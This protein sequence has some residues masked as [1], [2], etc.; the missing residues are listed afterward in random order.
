MG[1][2]TGWLLLLCLVTAGK[3]NFSPTITKFVFEVCEDVPIDSHAFTIEATDPD[4]DTLTYALSGASAAFFN[5][6]PNT[7]VVTVK[8]AL[9]RESGV[10]MSVGVTVGDGF[11]LTPGT[12]T[13]ILNDANDNSPVFQNP[14]FDV[15]VQENTAV[16]T[17]LFK[18]TATDADEGDAGAVRYSITEAV[19]AQGAEMFEID[20]INGELK[21]KGKLN[22]V[23][24]SFYRL[25][26]TAK[27][28]GGSCGSGAHVVQSS[29]VFSFIT[30]VDVPDLDPVFISAPYIG[31]VEENSPVD[32]SVLTVTAIDQDR[33]INDKILYS[34]QDSTADGLFKISQDDGIISV[35]SG[36]DREVTG[37][38]VTLTV[39]A[40]ESK[41]NVNGQPATATATVQINIIDVNDNPPQ[42][43]KCDMPSSCV[44]AT[45]FTGEVFEHSL[46]AISINMTVK[47]P[48]RFVKTKLSLEGPD[49]DVFSV[50]PS[51]AGAESVVQLLVSQPENLD[52]E[53]KQQMILQM[54]AVDEDK[55]T[56]QATATV[57]IIIKD[58]NDNSP[59]F[60]Q[61]T[62]K[63]NVSEHSP[64]GTEVAL[65][66]AEDPDTMDAGKLTYSLLP[67][68]ILEYF[69]V[70]S[71]TGKVYVKNEDLLDRELRSLFSAT[72]QARDTDGNPGTTV[73]EITLTDINDQAPIINRAIYR[74]FV[75]EGSQ[76]AFPIEATDGDEAG[77][78]NSEIV[79]SI[80]ESA[81][82]HNFSIDA[83]TGMLKN[84]GELD[85]EVLDPK[86]NG[87]I[88][89]TVF[90]TDK[91]TPPLNSSVEV[92]ITVGDINDNTPKFK[93]ESYNF[94]I[95]EGEKGASVGFV[96][97]K[98]LDQTTE[99]NR[100]SFSIIDGSFGSF[101]VRSTADEEG[102]RGNIMV[103]PD[104]EL[105]YESARKKFMLRLEA[106]DLEQEK[107]SVMVEVHVL[108][109]NDERPEF[110]P[111]SGISVKENTTIIEP[112]GK[113]IALDKD[114]NHSLVYELESVKCSCNGTEK[115]C[116][117][118]T[119]DPNGDVRVNQ[120]ETVDYEECDKAVMEVQVVDLYTEKGESNSIE[121]GK[122][123]INIEDINDNA[124]QFIYSDS[125]LVVVSESASK[126][127]SVAGVK[128][129]DRDSG[130][131]RQINFKV[132][133]VQFENMAT[134]TTTD[135]RIPFEAVTTQQG[136]DYVG[137]IQ[138]TEALD[139]T[140]KGKYLVT[141][142]ATDSGGLSSST[143]L[144]I[145][146][147][148]ETFRTD[149]QFRT[150]ELEVQNSLP[151]ITRA[152]TTA[153]SAAVE[154]VDIKPVSRASKNAVQT[155]MRAYFIYRNGTALTRP[156][157]EKKL[158]NPI[159][160]VVL[161][162]LGLINIGSPPVVETESD[163]VKYVLL[164]MVAG[165]V[166]VLAVLTTSLLC[167]RRNFRRKLKAANA[168]KST[169][170]L[171][172]DN[173]KGGAVVPGTNKY[174]M[175]GANPVLNLNIDT[176]I[177]LDLDSNEETSDSDKVSLNSLD[178]EYGKDDDKKGILWDNE[179]DEPPVYN[180]PLEAA[181]AQLGQNK[182][183][184]KTN[185]MVGVN[186]PMFDTTDL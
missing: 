94:S 162:E 126:G 58:T 139:L 140:L 118:F 67:Q 141:A 138:T 181:L 74:E 45:Q 34:I 10:T 104:I 155:V 41:M 107:A 145:F 62:Y 133:A 1:G 96:H 80:K 44:I 149:L 93:A 63:L 92:V 18:F 4:G 186:N 115:P 113:F 184:S 20:V 38:T 47:D 8:A 40:T 88:E 98:D 46:G 134:N 56:F 147:I 100:I 35:S 23:Q 105:D 68:S 157:V 179:A 81:H 61:D 22:Y 167:T 50:S 13:I 161:D 29:D 164:G 163:P 3:A 53:K 37:D 42:F 160:F 168:M 135:M 102:Y 21:L 24:H 158:S 64:V 48:D 122:M 124:P 17:S 85:R 65:V 5:V 95:K 32:K 28:L 55:T 148:D 154:V 84:S 166:I 49:K 78:V 14:A 121:P 136:D 36:I 152:L 174:T 144:E 39:K 99:Y 106:A 103:D 171:N 6:N 177:A 31:S 173:Q 142:T 2:L 169:T 120:S 77:T 57:T 182:K 183:N 15:S 109:V 7:G 83:K 51:V 90:A 117:W 185:T 175:E 72:L 82:S 69:D 128:A 54:I 60:P 111:I 76:I 12:L 114:T 119:L 91:G 25:K 87:R 131:N 178:L 130:L 97:A 101:I 108:D 59:T 110:G 137:I 176:T 156:E 73:L 132:T 143:V 26:V 27:D 170:M 70:D 116:S 159:H 52:F 129:S 125:V 71:S 112:V 172:S 19:P 151:E 79:F 86:L 150:P 75:D 146:T 11:N 165:L 66:T 123:V 89:L 127:T 9:D 43:Y 153:T 16:G 180:E 30:V 33:G